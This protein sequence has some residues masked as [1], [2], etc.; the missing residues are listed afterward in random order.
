MKHV[1]HP[2]VAARRLPLGTTDGMRPVDAPLHAA[3]RRADAETCSLLLEHHAD[4]GARDEFGRTPA[5][6]AVAAAHDRAVDVL[7]LLLDAGFEATID[8]RDGGDRSA[9]GIPTLPFVD[10][11][12]GRARRPGPAAGRFPVDSRGD[13]AGDRCETVLHVAARAGARRCVSLLLQSAADARAPDRDG[14]TPRDAALA[15]GARTARTALLAGVRCSERTGF[16]KCQPPRGPIFLETSVDALRPVRR[17]GSRGR[18]RGGRF[19]AGARGAAARAPHVRGRGRAAARPRRRGPRARPPRGRLFQEHGARGRRRG[20][21][22][23]VARRPA[24]RRCKKSPETGFGRPSPP[25][26]ERTTP[27]RPSSGDDA[28]EAAK[29][30]S[31]AIRPGRPT[32]RANAS[33]IGRRTNAASPRR[34]RNRP[35]PRPSSNIRLRCAGT[36][37][38]ARPPPRRRGAAATRPTRR[39]A[40]ATA[41][42]PRP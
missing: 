34:R 17:R 21:G 31:K 39:R 9:R 28:R 23:F 33:E 32:P 13:A 8:A 10:G 12:A 41:T 26:F 7:A 14:L 19:S 5:H 18:L 3:A 24:G 20:P 37:R 25:F 2:V 35:T 22:P 30:S 11:D 27:P 16:R 1:P 6:V 36:T 38:T 29:E 42:G 40:R 4:P 15:A